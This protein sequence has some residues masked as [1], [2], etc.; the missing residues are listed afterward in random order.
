[1]SLCNGVLREVAGSLSLQV[2]QAGCSTPCDALT[3]TE[4]VSYRS[5]PMILEVVSNLINP[6]IL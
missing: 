5:D 3:G 2:F 6:V 4:V 1:M